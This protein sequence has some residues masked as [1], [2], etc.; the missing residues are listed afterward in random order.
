MLVIPDTNVINGDLFLEGPLIRAI[1]AAETQTNVRLVIPEVVVDEMR[2]R[3]QRKLKETVEAANKVRRDYT[4]LRGPDSG[5]VELV[6]DA[7]NEQAILDR[8]EQ[9]VQRLREEDRILPYPTVSPEELSKR[10]IGRQAP[11]LEK[12]RGMRDTLIWLTVK[13]CM[14]AAQDE[15]TEATLVTADKAFL[16]Q[17]RSKL[18]ERLVR[19]LTNAKVAPDSVTVQPNLRKV[20]DTIIADYLSSVGWVTQVIDSGEIGG[21][22]DSD[23]AV[24]LELTD[25]V[26]GNVEVFEDP[27]HGGISGFLF[28]DF[29]IIEEVRLESVE[30]TLGLGGGEALVESK[31][32][33]EAAVQGYDNPYFGESLTVAL[34]ITLSSIVQADGEYLSVQS[35][36][37]TDVT[38]KDF[39][40]AELDF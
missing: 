34:E 1:V 19:E 26:Y 18:N 7:K 16:D 36:Q 5:G 14:I 15:A 2:G 21:L 35:H 27:R 28:V 6:I 23:D 37:I 30:R 10:S 32:A 4:R 13:E 3:V 8:F 31:W 25:W 24:L 40:S 20:V 39:F 17:S 11:F 22:L 33:G 9:L 29:D 38:V 12:D